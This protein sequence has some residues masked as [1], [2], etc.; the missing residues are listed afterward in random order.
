MKKNSRIYVAGHTGFVGSALTRRLKAL[1][2]KNL[3]LKTRKEI[4]LADQGKVNKLFRTLR[5]EYVFLLA[6][7]VGG[8]RANNIYPADFIYQNIAIASNV[9]QAA[10]RYKAKKL[11]FPGSACMFPKYCPQPMKEDYLLTGSIEPTN[12]P[13]AV[14]K[15]AGVKMCQVYNRQYKTKFISVVPATIYGPGDHFNVDGH[16]MAALIEKF[17]GRQVNV[18]GT[19]KPK[20]EFIFI[21]DV[22]NA[23]IFLMQ[24]YSGSQIINI[25]TGVEV[26]I[27]NLAQKIKDI[28]LFKGKVTF[29]IS[30]PDGMLRRL[31]DSTKLLDMGW[32]PKVNLEEGIKLTCQWYKASYNKIRKNRI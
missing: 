14:A 6:A 12:E 18:W 32:K 7:K 31:L 2:F 13:F 10:Y 19:G 15:I 28:T 4:D 24:N 29:D 20:R 23:L 27:K 1:G 26:S 16:V 17:Y 8:I 30:K 22:V 9:I 25:G 5:P 3:I 21:D 11:L